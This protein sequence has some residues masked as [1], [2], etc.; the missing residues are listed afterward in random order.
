VEHFPI[1]KG[2]RA[3]G[4]ISNGGRHCAVWCQMCMEGFDFG[5][6][7]LFGMALMVEKYEASRL[8]DIYILYTNRVMLGLQNISHMVKKLLGRFFRCHCLHP[9][10]TL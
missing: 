8:L 9:R 3:E 1:L 2:D 7:H 5:N 10:L 4:S 6:A